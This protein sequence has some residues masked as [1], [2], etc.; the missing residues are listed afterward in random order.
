MISIRE[1]FEG[2]SF[3]VKRCQ[4]KRG[5]DGVNIVRTLILSRTLH[6]NLNE[7]HTILERFREMEYKH[8]FN[9]L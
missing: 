6:Y 5:G 1:T 3:T 2:V 4:Y 7:K 9:V 8:I